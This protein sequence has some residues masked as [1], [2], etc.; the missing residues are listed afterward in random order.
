MSIVDTLVEFLHSLMGMPLYYPLVSLIIIGDALCPLLPSETI[1]NLSGAFSASQGVPNLWGVFTAAVVG[2]MIGDNLCFALGGKLIGYVE[3][4]DPASKAGQAITWV[5]RN[6]KR[7]AGITIIVGRFLPWVRWVATIVLG[8]VQYRWGAFFFYDT[9]GVLLWSLIG[10]GSG[11]VGGAL[12]ADF[13]FLAM[14][15]GLLVGSLV[16]V[17]IRWAQVRLSERRDVRQGVSVI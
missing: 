11:Y 9:V 14:L 4:L 2:G 12:L 6:M 5:R 10:V 13:P 17:L 1:L 8:S 3:R 15:A 16:G 7:G